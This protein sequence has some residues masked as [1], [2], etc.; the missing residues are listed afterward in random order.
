MGRGNWSTKDYEIL[1]RWFKLRREKEE[2]CST[3]GPK[4]RPSPRKSRTSAGLSKRFLF[5]SSIHES[6]RSGEDWCVLRLRHTGKTFCPSTYESVRVCPLIN[7]VMVVCNFLSPYCESVVVSYSTCSSPQL[8]QVQESVRPQKI[9]N[10]RRTFK[11]V[12]SPAP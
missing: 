2:V 12:S 10:Q 6:R 9:T 11:E 4:G 1:S 5:S 8:D 7:L 3:A